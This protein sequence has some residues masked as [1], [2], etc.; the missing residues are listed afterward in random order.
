MDRVRDNTRT[1]RVCDI[2]RLYRVCD[3]TRTISVEIV[4][5]KQGL[6]TPYIWQ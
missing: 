1:D 2:T 6:S 5:S 3:I 4:K